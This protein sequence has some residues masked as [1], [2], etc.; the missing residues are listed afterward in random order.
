MDALTCSH[1]SMAATGIAFE[2]RRE[3][4]SVILLASGRNVVSSAASEQV[5]SSAAQRLTASA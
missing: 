3:N 5:V 2:Q 1:G 4:K